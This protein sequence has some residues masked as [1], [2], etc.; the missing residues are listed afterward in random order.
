MT[1]DPHT[2]APRRFPLRPP[3]RARQPRQELAPAGVGS[4]LLAWLIDLVAVA[5]AAAVAW[6]LT[7]SPL[8]AAIVALE[9]LIGF[10]VWEGHTGCTPGQLALGLRTVRVGTPVSAGAAAVIPRALIFGAAHLLAVVG[11]PL[12]ILTALA[13][14]RRRGQAW[15]DK[16]GGLQVVDVRRSVRGATLPHLPPAYPTGV[17]GFTPSMPQPVPVRADGPAPESPLLPRDAVTRIE[18][19]ERPP[20]PPTPAPAPAPARPAFAFRLDDGTVVPVDR[21]G[22]LGRRPSAP[23]GQAGALLVAVPD[24]ERSMSRTHARFGVTNGQLWY[25]DL[26]SG[27]G[28]IVQIPDGR[29]VDLTPHSRVALQPGATLLLGTRSVQVIPYEG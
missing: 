25:E 22:Y 17:P 13:D 21:G 7:S 28:T 8:V 14:P 4:R 29:S 24:P 1:I 23:E 6:L 18:N 2:V 15:H 9:L 20:V 11:A 27:N 12:L 10:V 16:V 5:A 19:P 3:A 26:G